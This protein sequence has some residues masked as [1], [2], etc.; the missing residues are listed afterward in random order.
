VRVTE[1]WHRLP[2][3]VVESP[4]LEIIKSCLD[5]FLGSWLWVALLEKRGLDKIT[6]S[7]PLLPQPFYDSVV[8]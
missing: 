2:G 3:E 6:C 8:L 4:C 7:G 1:P 5:M